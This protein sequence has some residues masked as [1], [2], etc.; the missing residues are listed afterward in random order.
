MLPGTDTI[1]VLADLTT[2]AAKHTEEAAAA[3]LVLGIAAAC[4]YAFRNFRGQDDTEQSK[5]PSLS[6]DAEINSPSPVGRVRQLVQRL[7]GHA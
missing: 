6:Q 5:A 7:R 4:Y 1:M 2:E 3:A